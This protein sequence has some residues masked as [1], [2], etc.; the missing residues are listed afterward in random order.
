VSPGCLWS[1]T[2]TEQLP[3]SFI[4]AGWKNG[5]DR[6]RDAGN[7]ARGRE[8]SGQAKDRPQNNRRMAPAGPERIP[9]D[10]GSFT[11]AV[12]LSLPATFRPASWTGTD[13]RY[14][15][16]VCIL[17]FLIIWDG[18]YYEGR[19]LDGILRAVSSVVRTVTG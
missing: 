3:A 15:I 11:V 7:K 16:G 14:V 1:T 13:M 5:F 2:G 4:R 8:S 6:S 17:T 9:V 12:A 19:Y 10:D 18:A